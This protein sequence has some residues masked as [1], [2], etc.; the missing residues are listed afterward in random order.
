M[1]GPHPAPHRPGAPTRDDRA[2]HDHDG[3]AP[4]AVLSGGGQVND[5]ISSRSCASGRSPSH[6][7]ATVPS[8]PM[9]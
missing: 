2:D 3:A 7:L 6:A 1:V 4:A 5:P 9:K 8:D